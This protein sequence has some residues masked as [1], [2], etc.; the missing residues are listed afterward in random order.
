[1][2]FAESSPRRAKIANSILA[3]S[4]RQ[5]FYFSGLGETTSRLVAAIIPAAFQIIISEERPFMRPRWLTVLTLFVLASPLLGQ[6]QQ[7]T[8]Q[9]FQ[10]TEKHMGSDFTVK[11]YAPSAEEAEKAFQAAFG[12]IAEYDR[13]MSDYNSESELS[14]LGKHSPQAK[15]VSVSQPL[16]EVLARACEISEKTDGAFDVTVGPL[17]K[18]WRR[19]RRQRELPT[20]EER[21]EALASVGW[22]NVELDREHHTVRLTKPRMRLDLGGIAPGYA[23]DQALAKIQALG[24]KSALVDA[25]GDV[26][27]GDPPPGEKGWKI[28]IAPLKA[29]GPPDR[30]LLLANS[31]ISTSGDAFRGIEI[32]GVRYSHIVDPKT[33]IGVKHRSSV[34]VIAPNGTTADAL[35]TA[36]SIAG[37]EAGMSLLK[38][39][40]GTEVR[41]VYQIDQGQVQERESSGFSKFNLDLRKR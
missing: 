9:R 36:M 8:W 22:Q 37:P 1:L 26:V 25:S 19:A 28:G 4:W 23:A 35:A 5:S 29:E 33:G 32:D 41:F 24:Y 13:M 2:A 11:L 15:P 40:P 30:F 17:T 7:A 27:L 10:R 6:D 20:D 39:F 14:Q 34:T 18:L 21:S 3:D 31:A 12:L 16:W 38:K